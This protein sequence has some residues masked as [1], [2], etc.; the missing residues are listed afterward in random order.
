MTNL[1]AELQAHIQQ[2][3]T[4][5][6][7]PGLK[8]ALTGNTPMSGGKGH[9]VYRLHTRETDYILKYNPNHRLPVLDAEVRGLQLIASLGKLRTPELIQYHAGAG[10]GEYILMQY[11]PRHHRSKT[12]WEQMGLGL[13]SL[14]RTTAPRF[15]L[16]YNNYIASLQQRNTQT[17]N[18]QDFL[19]TQ[20]LEPLVALAIG[21]GK[22]PASLGQHF[23]RLYYRL[24]DFI[25]AEP[26]ALL[27][28]DLWHGNILAGPGN[29]A[30]VIDPA[31][32]FG[33]REMDLAMTRLFAGFDDDFYRAY[34]ASY[35]LA[36]G[37]EDRLPILQLYPLL[38]HVNLF[39]GGYAAEVA[40]IV[41]RF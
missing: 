5:K 15:G 23:S 19:V 11:L 6:L 32:Y 10:I 28:G 36:P 8:T 29:T 13:A 3:L 1:P 16:D 17:A 24:A 14:H 40:E 39:G 37:F 30:Y 7:G 2:S 26:P 34:H 27:H 35:P 33:H 9:G 31:V 41:Q 20:R 22:M 4:A 18:W 38:V 25:P 21:G 12:Y